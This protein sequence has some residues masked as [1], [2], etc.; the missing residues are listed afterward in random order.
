MGSPHQPQVLSQRDVPGLTRAVVP[1]LR[2]ASV[3]GISV[4]PNDDS[5]APNTPSTLQCDQLGLHTVRQSMHCTE[6]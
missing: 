3:V 5:P 1:L 6:E 2:R 4:G